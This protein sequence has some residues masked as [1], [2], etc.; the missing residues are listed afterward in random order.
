MLPGEECCVFM[1]STAPMTMAC[2]FYEP[3]QNTTHSDEHLL[4]TSNV[5]GDHLDAPSVATLAPAGLCPRPEARTAGLAGDKGDSGNELIRRLANIPVA[6]VVDDNAPVENRRCQL[7]DTVQSTTL[8]I[9]GC[10]RRQ[11]QDWFDDIEAAISSRLTRLREMQNVWTARNT[12]G[13]QGYA[14]HNEWMNVFAAI[15]VVY[16]P[17]TKTA[18][19]LLSA[20]GITLLTEKTQILQRWTEHFRDVLNRPSAIP[21]P[22]SPSASIEDQRRPRPPALSPR[23]HQGRTAALQQEGARI[24]RNKCCDPQVRWTLTH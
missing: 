1:V 20:D 14:K 3:A 10:A 21:T 16:H 13:I 6:T 23:N 7:R 12:E 4:P 9:Y 11:H 8:A 18:A 15:K 2:S 22:S 17:P 5:R 24:G 19:P